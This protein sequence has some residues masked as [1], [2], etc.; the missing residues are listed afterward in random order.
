MSTVHFIVI[1]HCLAKLVVSPSSIIF[2]SEL[3]FEADE[4]S[5]GHSGISDGFEVDFRRPLLSV[6]CTVLSRILVVKKL[7]PFCFVVLSK[8]L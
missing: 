3:V 2:V 8:V 1:N 5:K 6:P 4:E 7:E